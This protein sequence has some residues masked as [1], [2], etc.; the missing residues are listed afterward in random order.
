MRLG[1]ILRIAGSVTLFGT[2]VT[3]DSQD[4][5]Q[6]SPATAPSSSLRV[7]LQRSRAGSDDSRLRRIDRTQRRRNSVPKESPG[8]R[9][10]MRGQNLARQPRSIR[11]RPERRKVIDSERTEQRSRRRCP[12]GPLRPTDSDDEALLLE[13]QIV[14][15]ECSAERGSAAAKPRRRIARS[16]LAVRPLPGVSSSITRRWSRLRPLC[17]LV[18]RLSCGLCPELPGGRF[19]GRTGFLRPVPCAS[20]R[21]PLSDSEPSRASPARRGASRTERSFVAPPASVLSCAARN[22]RESLSNRLRMPGAWRRHTRRVD[23]LTP[24]NGGE[25]V[26]D[27]CGVKR[28][29]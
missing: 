15:V 19:H 13:A 25:L 10:G 24:I 28:R 8:R 29:G 26:I 14:D 23:I 2:A 20:A 16:H 4:A 6:S 1:P 3:L 11:A 18:R 7:I 17:G 27:P 9:T 5:R 21:L 12:L 22:T